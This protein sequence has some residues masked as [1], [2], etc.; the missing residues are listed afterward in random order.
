MN[1]DQDRALEFLI[2]HLRRNGYAFVTPTPA[3][4]ARVIARRERA[5]DLRDVF[6]WSLPFS[7]DAVG[8]YVVTLLHDAGMLEHRGDALASRVRVS[9]LDGDYFLHSAFPTTQADAVFFGPDSYRFAAF[10]REALPRLGPCKHIVDL[11]A[12]SGVG[13]IVASRLDAGAFVTLTDS[14]IHAVRLAAINWVAADLRAVGFKVGSGLEALDDDRPIDCIIANPPYIADPAHRAYRDG[15]AMHGGE[16]SVRW[17]LEAAR[18]L[19]PGGALLLYTGSAI[20]KGEDKLKAALFEALDGFDLTYGER[21]PDVF[22]EELDRE[23]Y[24]GV[25][26]IAAV[27]LLAVKR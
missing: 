13:A 3:T 22:G 5:Q 15:G 20:V 8:D 11:G 4:H 14:N 21:D 1:G 9:T 2:A 24:A 16:I 6:G 19:A 10:I 12:G 26:R 27:G 17:A 25:E 23:A 18:R 7:A